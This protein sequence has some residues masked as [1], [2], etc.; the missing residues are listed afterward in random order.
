MLVLQLSLGFYYYP[1]HKTD[2]CASVLCYPPNKVASASA[3]ARPSLGWE[4][5]SAGGLLIKGRA[6]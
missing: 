2:A 3:E 6:K 1:A 5:R 4:A